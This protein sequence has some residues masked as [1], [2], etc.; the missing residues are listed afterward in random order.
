MPRLW[1]GTTG[2][3]FV[4]ATLTGPGGYFLYQTEE[5][6]HCL[7]AYYH[8]GR[9]TPRVTYK[10][11][12]RTP[13]NRLAV[14]Y[15][16]CKLTCHLLWSS[17]SFFPQALSTLNTLFPLHLGYYHEIPLSC[18]LLYS[19]HQQCTR[20]L[21]STAATRERHHQRRTIRSRSPSTPTE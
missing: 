12:R 15:P 20:R 2:E 9:R 17:L 1:Q 8:K 18:R 5:Q 16:C 7:Y 19:C 13:T 3:S 21:A 4:A 11:G 6:I 14:I 10:Q